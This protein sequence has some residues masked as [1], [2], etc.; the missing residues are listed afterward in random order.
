MIFLTVLVL[1][2]CLV[3]VRPAGDG[4]LRVRFPDVGQA[5]ACLISLNGEHILIDGGNRNDSSKIWSLLKEEGITELKAVIATHPDEDHLGGLPAAF[6]ASK[7]K[8]A[9][10]SVA[11]YDSPYPYFADF[12][13]KASAQGL[14][15]RIPQAG[16]VLTIGG[17][18]LVFLTTPGSFGNNNDD[19]LCCRLTYGAYSFLLMADAGAAVE[20]RLLSGNAELAA[21][22]LKVAHHGSETSTS[23]PFLQ[24]VAPEY[25]VISVGKDNAYGFPKRRTLDRLKEAGCMIFRTDQMGDILFETDGKVLTYRS[26]K[27]HSETRSVQA[28]SDAVAE[29]YP[30]EIRFIGNKRSGV[31]HKRTC[32]SIPSEQNRMLFENRETAVEA[33][34]QPCGR[35]KP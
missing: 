12:K 25:A 24:A 32:N 34:Y 3:F 20:E 13:A 22:V 16:E 26:E 2:V 29:A 18:K 31:F 6:S 15:L 27:K 1:A 21:D 11:D 7:V 5:D 35:C 30:N 8:S 17:A 10:C 14:A 28:P 9:Y 19:S 4:V 33:G 23:L